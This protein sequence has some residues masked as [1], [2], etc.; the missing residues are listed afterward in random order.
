MSFTFAPHSPKV[1]RAD[2]NLIAPGVN[3][4]KISQPKGHPS[5]RDF[6]AVSSNFPARPPK[7]AFLIWQGERRG[8]AV[9]KWQTRSIIFYPDVP[10]RDSRRT[11]AICQ[12]RVRRDKT[13]VR[14][15]TS[16]KRLDLG[17]SYPEGGNPIP[18]RA[19]A[20]ITPSRVNFGQIGGRLVGLGISWG[21][22]SRVFYLFISFLIG[23]HFFFFYISIDISYAFVFYQ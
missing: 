3:P 8:N 21:E 20:Q 22:R 9:R 17:A 12:A 5:K 1:Q 15:R 19:R 23:V 11:V 10:L 7:P 16:I 14:P 13:K 4:P 18:R 6:P 2:I